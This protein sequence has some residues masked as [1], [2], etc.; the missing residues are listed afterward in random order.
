MDL[1]LVEDAP[2]DLVAAALEY[3]PEL[4]GMGGVFVAGGFVRAFYEQKPP[5]DMDLFFT[6]EPSLIA[7]RM[8]LDHAGWEAVYKGKRCWEFRKDGKRVQCISVFWLEPA[9]CIQQFDFTV[10]AG[11]VQIGGPDCG[12]LYRHK[13]FLDD[14]LEK[15]LQLLSCPAPL[16]TLERIGRYQSYGYQPVDGLESEVLHHFNQWADEQPVAVITV[17]DLLDLAMSAT[18]DLQR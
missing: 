14:V 16:D 1:V 3:C 13:D 4:A 11:A 10:C 2:A 9:E 6:A 18:T 5:K 8:R 12:T 17:T 15:R 7:M